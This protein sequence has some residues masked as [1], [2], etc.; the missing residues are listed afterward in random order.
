MSAPILYRD[1]VETIEADEA[2]THAK[3]IEVMTAGQNLV[4][5]KHGGPVRIS[6]A[7]AHGFLK[8]ELIVPDHLPPELAQGL[9]ARPATY[10][11]V[12]R[13]SHA[14]GEL[15]DD[16]KVSTPRG[17]AIKVFHVEGEHLSPFEDITTQDF[18][19]DTGSR[20]FISGNAKTFLQAFKP[21]AKLAPHL[22]DTAKGVV[23]DLARGA[24][25]VL[26]VVGYNS[27]K[28]DFYGH[29]KFHPLAE[30]YYSQTPY[31]YGDHVAKFAVRPATPGLRALVEEKFDPQTP[32]ALRE[33]TVEFFRS[34]PAEFE[35][36]VQLNTDLEKMPIE[37]ATAKWSEEESPYRVVAHLRLPAQDAFDQ[38][39]QDFV[40]RSLSFNPAHC[41][42]THRPLGSVNRARRVVYTA[43]SARRRREQG[44]S[45][46]EPAR[47]EEVPA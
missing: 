41:L 38:E 44:R 13:I 26:H 15:L 22:S 1:D 11:V 12:V 17:I 20:E 9:F 6:H 29:P 2:E 7:K 39:R 31:R 43:M 10:P 23:S 34:Q 35:F 37:D 30:A 21:N 46:V 5:E 47:V 3:I 18:V 8:G 24:N 16:S 32:N 42:A 36:A 19:F 14:P 45:N 4:S 40:D 27:A 33:A 25:A 28:L